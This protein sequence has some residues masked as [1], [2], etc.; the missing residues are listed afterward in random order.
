MEAKEEFLFKDDTIVADI[1]NEVADINKGSLQY[2]QLVEIKVPVEDI[3]EYKI[4]VRKSSIKK[5]KNACN[6]IQNN[7]F[8]WG[9]LLIGIC[10]MFFGAFLSAII[11]GVKYELNFLGVMFY[12]ICPMIAVASLIGYIACR[13]SLIR[14]ASYLANIVNEHLVLDDETESE[15]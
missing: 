12:T 9:E 7:K 11:S 1:K 3:N 15:E 14:D 6:E 5:I 8:T 4:A 13:K 2:N 10:T